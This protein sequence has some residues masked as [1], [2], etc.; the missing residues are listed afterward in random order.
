M[1]EKFRRLSFRVR[2]FLQFRSYRG[3]VLIRGDQ[4]CMTPLARNSVPLSPS[5]NWPSINSARTSAGIRR[6]FPAPVLC[7]RGS[8]A[9]AKFQASLFFPVYL[10]DLWFIAIRSAASLIRESRLNKLSE[11]R[12]SISLPNFPEFSQSDSEFSWFRK[13]SKIPFPSCDPSESCLR[14]GTEIHDAITI[15]ENS[16]WID[17]KRLYNL[18]LL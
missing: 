6:P 10:R 17:T 8:L 16:E 3:I 15:I 1:N 4:I 11:S 2:D 7:P 12:G 18:R 13:G 9:S 14:A 5:A